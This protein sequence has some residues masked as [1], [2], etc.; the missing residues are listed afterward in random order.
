MVA[1]KSALIFLA[2]SVE[3]LAAV[4]A[5]SS[6]V[7]AT[8]LGTVSVAN[9]PRATTTTIN[10]LTVIKKVIQKVNVIVIPVAK[11]TTVKETTTILDTVT[12]GSDTDTATET[13]T[14]TETTSTTTTTTTTETFTFTTFALARQITT[15]VAAPADFTPI[16]QTTDV[17]KRDIVKRLTRTLTLPGEGAKEY[18]QRVD[19][20]KRIPQYTT[21]TVTTKVQGARITLKPVTKTKTTVITVHDTTTVY[22]P[23]VSETITTVTIETFRALARKL[24]TTTSTQTVTVQTEVP[25]FIQHDACNADNILSRANGGGLFSSITNLSGD[26]QESYLGDLSPSQCC[27]ECMLR[28]NCRVSLNRKGKCYIYLA[29][30]VKICANNAQPVWGQYKTKAGSSGTVP[31][32]FWS[33]GPC[34]KIVNGGAESGK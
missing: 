11:T 29:Q 6:V 20:T 30:D 10:K 24:A 7:C 9:P 3:A 23:D 25:A 1:F 18:V 22:G 31:N 8:K 26:Q 16:V 5:S 12:A 32:T 28:P 19:C 4:P 21:K 13:S 34:G 2:L 15:T 33:N 17:A 14:S 27:S